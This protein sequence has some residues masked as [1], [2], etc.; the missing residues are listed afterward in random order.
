VKNFD[1][2]FAAWVTVWIIFFGYEFMVARRITRL[3]ED[4]RQLKEQSGRQ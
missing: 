4:L 2:L 1:F 3:R